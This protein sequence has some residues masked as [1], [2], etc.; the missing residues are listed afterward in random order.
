MTVTTDP[1]GPYAIPHILDGIPL[2]IKHVNVTINRENF[3]FNPT[4][5]NPMTLSATI[6]SSEGATAATSSPF[7]VTNCANLKFAPTFTASTSAHT[8][9]AGGASLT[10]KVTQLTGPGSSQANFAKAKIDLPKQLPSRLTTLQKACLAAVFEANPAACSPAS[11]VGHV[12]VLTPLLPVPLEGPAYF[13][14]HGNQAFPTL[15]FYLQGYG[16]TLVVTSD[17]FIKKGIT[18][19]TLHTIP[20]A[21][22]TLFELTLPEGPHSALAANTNLCTTKLTIPTAFV[23][24]NNLEIHKQTPLTV[25]GCH[26]HTHK[27]TSHCK[28]QH[29]HTTCTNTHKPKHTNTKH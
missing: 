22:F 27:P 23:A 8:S 4:N 19:G 15:T 25:T 12:R 29:S 17:T 16:I 10:L 28:K 11:I 1:S 24:Q 13:V 3:T 18:S 2:E 7:Q 9:K 5:C 6:T 20:D 14:S 26:K 21:P